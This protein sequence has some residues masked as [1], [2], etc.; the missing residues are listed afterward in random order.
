MPSCR[1]LLIVSRL[2][3]LTLV[4]TRRAVETCKR[5]FVGSSNNSLPTAGVFQKNFING[6][7]SEN[8]FILSFISGAT[9]FSNSSD[10]S[11]ATNSFICCTSF[12]SLNSLIYCPFSQSSFVVSNIGPD[13]LTLSRVNSRT[14]SERENLSFSSGCDQPKRHKKFTSASGK[15]PASLYK[16]RSTGSRRFESF[17]CSSFLRVGKWAN[18][19]CLAASASKSAI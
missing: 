9:C 18:T 14:N 7:T 11:V 1:A 15:Y 4:R 16:R 6:S 13:F 10:T 3:S 17:L 8:L 5:D 12:S 19:G 2:Q